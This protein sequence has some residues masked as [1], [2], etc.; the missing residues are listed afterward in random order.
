[1]KEPTLFV[2]MQPYGKSE[3][4]PK[5]WRALFCFRAKILRETQQLPDGMAGPSMA[6]LGHI[7]TLNLAGA[8]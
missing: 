4:I 3:D 1:M 6:Y 8:G 2:G 5:F 7:Y